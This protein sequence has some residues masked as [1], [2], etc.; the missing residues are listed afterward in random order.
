MTKNDQHNK[1]IANIL[2]HIISWGFVFGFPIIIATQS[3]DSITDWGEH[4]RP[5]GTLFFSSFILFYINYFLLIPQ[6][7]F[8]AKAKLYFGINILLIICL[9]IVLYLWKEL[10]L[11]PELPINLTAKNQPPPPHHFSI[12]SIR[13]AFTMV[14]TIGLSAAIRLSSR[15]REIETARREAEKARTEAELKNLRNQLNPHF[16]LNTLNNIYALISF[17]TEKAQMAVSEL[18]RLLRHML[19]ENQQ[20]F[21][22]LTKEGKFIQSYI[23]LMRIRLTKQVKVET[24]IE[25]AENSQTTI[26]P[27]I[28]VSLVENA[29]KHGISPTQKSY[30]TIVIGENENEI[31]CHIRNSYHPKNMEDKSGSGIGLEQVSKRLELTYKGHYHWDKGITNDKTEYYSEITIYKTN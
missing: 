5:T 24:N 21:V 13:D 2:I 12:F 27:L 10:F 28:F 8:K 17:D 22:P 3:E 25:I 11:P 1:R 19:Y 26:A 7:L 16:L 18:S 4:M 15:W 29:F 30:I 14:L 9:L 23:E 20:R 31:Y 6:L